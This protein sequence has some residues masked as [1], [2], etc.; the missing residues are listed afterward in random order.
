[1]QDRGRKQEDQEWESSGSRLGDYLLITIM[2][3]RD[4]TWGKNNLI[5]CQLK[6]V[7]I[8]VVRDEKTDIK[9][10]PFLPTF[11]VS[12]S[13][14]LAPLHPFLLS[15]AGNMVSIYGQYIQS[16]HSSFFCPSSMSYMGCVMNIFSGT[17]TPSSSFSMGQ[18]RPLLTEKTCSPAASTWAWTHNTDSDSLFDLWK[19]NHCL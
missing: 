8:C 16:I 2:D 19:S 6:Q 9:I 5:Y 18:D 17:W 11:P 12:T 14:L 13:S 7:V 3:K 1:M 4:L 15:S 10:T